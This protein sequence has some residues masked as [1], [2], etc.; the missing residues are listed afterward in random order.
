MAGA[1]KGN[2]NAQKHGFYSAALLPGEDEV[3]EQAMTLP[4]DQDIAM[5]RTRVW[6]AMMAEA[7]GQELAEGTQGQVDRALG[8]LRDFIMCKSIIERNDRE[9]GKHDDSL[10]ETL[11]RFQASGMHKAVFKPRKNGNGKARKNG[12]G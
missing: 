10:D 12:A 11:D 5:L 4:I 9:S 1:P 7:S 6:R 8:R 3:F 2:K